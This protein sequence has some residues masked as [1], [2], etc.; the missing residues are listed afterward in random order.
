MKRYYFLVHSGISMGGQPVT[1]NSVIDIEPTTWIAN[2]INNFPEQR[3]I[4]LSNNEITF[5][6][7][8]KLKDL[9]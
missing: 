6:E 8:K 4:L 5:S 1:M 3:A 7:Y 2:I 9:L